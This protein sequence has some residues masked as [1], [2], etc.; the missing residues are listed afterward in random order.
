MKNCVK[1]NYKNPLPS[2]DLLTPSLLLLYPLLFNPCLTFPTT[3]ALV[4]F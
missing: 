1:P 2:P 4:N 3:R